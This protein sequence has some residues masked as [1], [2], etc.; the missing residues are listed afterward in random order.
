MSTG[1]SLE[2]GFK[3]PH[4]H[5]PTARIVVLL[6]AIGL[7]FAYCGWIVAGLRG[8]LWG[9]VV[10][11]AVFAAI[12][13]AP[14]DLCLAAMRAEPLWPGDVP[15]LDAGAATLCHKAGLSPPP[16]LYHI[17]ADAPLAFSLGDGRSSAI[18]VDDAVLT[19][20]TA[21][22]RCGVLAHEIAHLSNGDLTLKALGFAIGWLVR[23]LSQLGFLLI[24]FG[25]L[26]RAFTAAEL[27]L[28]QLAIL[29]LA[30]VA[31]GFLRLAIS[32]TLEEEADA[33]AVE[34]T[35]DPTGLATALEKLQ[36]WDE[37]RWH[38]LAPGRRVLHLP[39]LF[40][41]HPPTAARITKLYEI[42]RRGEDR[43]VSDRHSHA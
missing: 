40:N 31:V 42:A 20:L 15:G 12:R 26:L 34:L 17:D 28:I 37:E 33:D 41:D 18:V 13:R 36:R 29:W 1:G 14:V 25:L 5:H 43:G 32:R 4:R 27:P 11:T 2:L 10:G 22:E 30:P 7:L 24:L 16:R 6:L 19:G 35:G 21:R 38:R 8:I 23:I 3:R 39:T 9:L